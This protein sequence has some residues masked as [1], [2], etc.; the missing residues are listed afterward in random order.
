VVGIFVKYILGCSNIHDKYD[1][2]IK[3]MRG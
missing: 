2:W 1:C 3:V